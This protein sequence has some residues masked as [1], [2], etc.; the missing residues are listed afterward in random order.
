MVEQLLCQ[1]ERKIIQDILNNWAT[2]RSNTIIVAPPFTRPR[3]IF[4]SLASS[5]YREK[6]APQLDR[7]FAISKLDTPDFK[8]ELDF[9]DA[10]L[11]AWGIQPPSN[12]NIYGPIELLEYGVRLLAQ[13]AVKPVLMI[14]RFHEAL[15]KLGEDIGTSLRNL[16]HDHA[17]ITVVELPISLHTLRERWDL[18]GGK[19]PFLASDWGQGHRAKLLKGYNK[20][21]IQGL[22]QNCSEPTDVAETIFQL[23]SGLPFLADVLI[24]DYPPNKEVILQRA[25][26]DAGEICRRLIKWLDQP[27]ENTYKR[28]LA[29]AL[30]ALPVDTSIEH[31]DWQDLLCGERDRVRP[32]I[33]AWASVKE[34]LASR[35]ELFFGSL[36]V[37]IRSKKFYEA[38]EVI[39][40]YGEAID[41]GS[42]RWTALKH[43]LEFSC[44]SDPF[45]PRWGSLNHCLAE[46]EVFI[47]SNDGDSSA[48]AL[49]M[50]L[51]WKNLCYQMCEFDRA[52]EKK[53]GLRIEQFVVNHASLM[54]CVENFLEFTD[55]RLNSAREMSDYQ[56]VKSIIEQPESLI[57]VYSFLKY[58]VKFWSFQGGDSAAVTRISEVMRQDFRM[59]SA[60]SKLGFVELLYICYDH[61]KSRGKQCSLIPDFSVIKEMES[62]YEIRKQQVHSMS[63]VSPQEAIDYF[64]F[65]A[66]LIKSF[67]EEIQV[68][69]KSSKLC[70]AGE[71]A[72]TLLT[73]IKSES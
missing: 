64:S 70:I 10:A 61:G 49:K 66:G 28:A 3:F 68:L 33:L 27:N 2:G 71:V 24:K 21:E 69:R 43:C 7:S 47:R 63:F 58:G 22:L 57:Q 41:T 19:S 11:K 56:F 16:E 25:R 38:L 32:T 17:L 53:K 55:L 35:D 52:A 45:N 65:C 39:H 23:T 72:E 62:M 8:S 73:Q 51:P 42:R 20:S 44:Y 6:Y 50:L 13:R 31:H 15:D 14:Q 36:A 12:K 26:N 9:V 54:D 5:Q 40:A 4:D 1:A 37:L 46:I 30:H 67:R 18:Q 48:Q 29:N 60:G 59:P 34:L